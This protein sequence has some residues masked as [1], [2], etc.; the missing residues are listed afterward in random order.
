MKTTLIGLVCAVAVLALYLVTTR[1][2]DRA[3]EPGAVAPWRPKAPLVDAPTRGAGY[4]RAVV[5][6]LPKGPYVSEVGGLE[7]EH[8]RRG[9]VGEGVRK[10]MEATFGAD[11]RRTD[12]RRASEAIAQIVSELKPDDVD[13]LLRCFEELKDPAFRW[14]F[15]WLV[16]QIPDDR[17]AD[18]LAEVYRIDPRTASDVMAAVAGPRSLAHLT[19]LY[20]TQPDPEI[21]AYMIGALS[22]SSWTGKE[23]YFARLAADPKRPDSDRAEAFAALGAHGRDRASLDYLLDAALGPERPMRD[24]EGRVDR[25]DPKDLRSAAVLGVVLRG[26]QDAVRTLLDRAENRGDDPA[27]DRM[28]DEHLAGYRGPDLSEFVYARAA[29]RRR[30][31][32]GELVQLGRAGAELDF[33]RL[34]TLEPY[35]ED[36]RTRALYRSY[37]VSENR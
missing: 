31:S 34:R 28:V 1:R 2:D 27:F 37:L 21:R 13:Y 36:E 29:R 18:A 25:A 22:R 15:A 19:G 11:W 5:P 14:Q 4:P 33:A 20:E 24:A 12:R 9:K 26:D 35:L 7:A 6:D 16:R 8:R 10:L 32:Y 3:A 17:F 23:E 30:L